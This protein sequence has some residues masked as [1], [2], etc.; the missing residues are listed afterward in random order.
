MLYSRAAYPMNLAIKPPRLV[1]TYIIDS[2]AIDP[3]ELAI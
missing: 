3:V 1:A 2:R